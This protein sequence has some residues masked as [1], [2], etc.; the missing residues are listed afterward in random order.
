[1]GEPTRSLL[2][3]C[4][5]YRNHGGH[6]RLVATPADASASE[7]ADRV[8]ECAEPL[9]LMVSGGLSVEVGM[10]E[11]LVGYFERPEVFAVS[12]R[13]LFSNGLVDYAGCIVRPDAGLCKLGYLLPEFDGGYIGRLHRP[14]SAAVLGAGCCMARADLL[15]EVSFGV[16]YETV[17]FAL[18]DACLTA[19]ERGMANVYTPFA[20]ARWQGA[21][22]LLSDA[23]LRDLRDQAQLM[24]RWGSAISQGD[25]SHNPNF[26]PYSPHYRL[27]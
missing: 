27:S 6:I 23:V 7:V 26:D 16:G 2:D 21:R 15:R 3:A 13:V 1:M 18:A 5:A 25:P 12:P 14:Y 19:Y 11:S 10:F 24:R 4:E 20:T 8:G 17:A 9:L 22:S